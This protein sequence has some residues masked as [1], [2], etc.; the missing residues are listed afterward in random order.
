[1]LP[2]KV[3]GHTISVS[4][5]GNND[6]ECADLAGLGANGGTLLHIRIKL[7][8]YTGVGADKISVFAGSIASG[9]EIVKEIYPGSTD[10]DI[11][12]GVWLPS[13]AQSV[14]LRYYQVGSANPTVRLDLSYYAQS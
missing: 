4:G 11:D 2:N 13:T 8:T 3:I 14:W 5:A 9:N 6:T 1:M 12:V 10:E 7:S